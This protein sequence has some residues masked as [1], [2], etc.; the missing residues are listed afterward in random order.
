MSKSLE[1]VW[2]GTSRRILSLCKVL[3]MS[4]EK[5]GNNV[6]KK[7]KEKY[8]SYLL[9]AMQTMVTMAMMI[10]TPTETAMIAP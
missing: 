9:L 8:G 5:E 1:L 3:K 10:T 6:L 2:K 4:V 7:D